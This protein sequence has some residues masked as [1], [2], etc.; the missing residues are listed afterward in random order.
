M[1]TRAERKAAPRGGRISRRSG[2]RSWNDFK[3]RGYTRTLGD[4]RPIWTRACL[5]ELWVF[6]QFVQGLSSQTRMRDLA[7]VH[8]EGYPDEIFGV[9]LGLS[10]LDNGEVGPGGGSAREY[11]PT[12]LN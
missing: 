4:Y 9:V 7:G 10:D 8:I 11:V 5:V 6:I 2:L 1:A 12:Q 3:P